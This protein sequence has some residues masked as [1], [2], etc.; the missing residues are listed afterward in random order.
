VFTLKNWLVRL[1]RWSVT[2][3][4]YWRDAVGDL[5][6]DL[7]GVPL[8]ETDLR[9][10]NLRHVDLRRADLERANL[11]DADLV[12][13][14]LREASLAGANLFKAN[15][16][17][18]DLT[19]ADLS[20]ADLREAALTQTRL[21]RTRLC[22][23]VL[24]GMDLHGIGLRQVELSGANLFGANLRG[25][26]LRNETLR[27][28]DLR[29]ADLRDVDFLGADLSGTDLSGADLSGANLSGA[30]LF[31]AYFGETV[32]V[33]VDL[34]GAIGLQGC[35]H[36]CP[37]IIDCQT[38]VRLGDVPVAFLRGCGLP[39][40][41]IEYL[42]RLGGQAD[43]YCPSFIRF[44]RKDEDFV[45]ALYANLQAEGVRCWLLPDD[46]TVSDRIRARIDRELRTGGKWIVVLSA[47]WLESPWIRDELALAPEEACRKWNTFLVPVQ[48]DGTVADTDLAWIQEL[49]KSCQ[50][51]NFRG[52]EDTVSYRRVL[53]ALLEALRIT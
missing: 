10:A 36:R 44:A 35:V 8:R 17:G 20:D 11:R 39:Q 26:S 13:S 3:W 21:E 51:V 22:R 4:N 9:G 14:D 50:V 41:L 1:L 2:N 43:R 31:R 49:K 45:E 7:R 40:V 18:A 46:L 47:A 28:A 30:G 48:I 33:D 24:S 6:L 12:G 19:D 16:C 42:S 34:T 29:D 32:L 23:A 53:S 38:F 52:C 27:E 25:L 5:P 37:S 15:L